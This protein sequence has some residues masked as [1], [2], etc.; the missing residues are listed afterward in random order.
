M[1]LTRVVGVGTLL[2]SVAAVA[3]YVASTTA[4]AATTAGPLAPT[5]T[6]VVRE[7][8]HR[9][10]P[11]PPSATP[12]GEECVVTSPGTT[13]T[14]TA[15][16]ESEPAEGTPGPEPTSEPSS[17]PTSE[18][19]SEP[20]SQPTSSQPTTP[21]TATPTSTRPVEHD[22]SDHDGEHEGDGVHEGDPAR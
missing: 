12:R 2:G 21:P 5:P 4:G 3:V 7:T 8:V 1:S 17:A 11:C 18:P 10:A 19:T 15:A 16:P 14:V 20:T 9:L 22:D 13:V 6:P